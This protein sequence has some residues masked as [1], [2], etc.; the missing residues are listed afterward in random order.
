ME[1]KLLRV[2]MKV[3]PFGLVRD[4]HSLHF[5]SVAIVAADQKTEREKTT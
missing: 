4:W 3:C 5:A 2:G 1:K